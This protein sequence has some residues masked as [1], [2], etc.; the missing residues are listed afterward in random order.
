MPTGMNVAELMAQGMS[1]E[2]ADM[3]MHRRVFGE[4]WITAGCPRDKNGQPV[5][6]GRPLGREHETAIAAA[7]RRGDQ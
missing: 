1:R 7:N 6:Q 5:E 3:E 2:A 4:N